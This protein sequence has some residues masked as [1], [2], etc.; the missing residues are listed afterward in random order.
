VSLIPG[1]PSKLAAALGGLAWSLATFF[2]V[3]L[4]VFER[5]SVLDSI[6]GSAE[7]IKRTW[8]EQMTM[9]IGFGAIGVALMLLSVVVITAFVAVAVALPGT[10]PALTLALILGAL[11]LFFLC[12]C[13]I[14]IL[15][16]CLELLYTAVLYSYARTGMLPDEI[17]PE[18]LP[19]A[20]LR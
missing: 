20:T 15:V 7:L 1:I 11:V 13:A 6:K 17:A 3:P 12:V 2:V 18:L 10:H 14:G 5:T 4:L 19:P 8:G 9:R 16:Q